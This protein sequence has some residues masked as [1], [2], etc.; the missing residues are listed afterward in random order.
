MNRKLNSLMV[1]VAL[2]LPVALNA[3]VLTWD[4]NV[5]ITSG[6][7][8][9]NT[10]SGYV[11]VDAA[12]LPVGQ[13]IS[14]VGLLTDL[15]FAFD[16]TTFD[17]STANT[18]YLEFNPDGTLKAL[19]FGTNCGPGYC[20]SGPNG[21]TNWFLVIGTY[22]EGKFG[23]DDFDFAGAT[24]AY[25]S[26]RGDMTFSLRDGWSVDEALADLAEDVT[27]AGPGASLADKIAIVR[28]HFDAGDVA[29]ACAMLTDFQNQAS[30]QAGKKL[31]IEQ[32]TSLTGQ[33]Q[34]IRNALGCE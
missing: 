15:S 17:E 23:P 26:V 1:V 22:R 31:T 20:G 6:P 28:A 7:G 27:G 11:S 21:T 24:T 34:T 9:G 4:F 29:A 13:G 30:A 5:L 16:G 12:G 25:Q 18:G 33:A 2:A 19:S 3:E 10:L 8:T 32:A 14:Q